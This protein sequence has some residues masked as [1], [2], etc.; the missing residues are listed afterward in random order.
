MSK[1]T[2]DS[3]LVAKLQESREPVNLCDESGRVLGRF[4][5]EPTA[6]DYEAAER[7]RPKLSEEELQMIES[8]PTFTTAEVIRHLESL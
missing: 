8:G 3:S 5:P 7:A 4:F 2:V 1:I 6:A